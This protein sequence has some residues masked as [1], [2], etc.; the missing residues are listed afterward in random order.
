MTLAVMIVIFM[1]VAMA[2]DIS[3][4][5]AIKIKARHSLNLALRAASSQVDMESLT[6]AENPRLEIMPHEAQYKF[7]HILQTNLALDTN[8]Q[9]YSN[10]PVDGK[11]D[12]CFFL[13]VN[14]PP[15]T[16]SYN[17]YSEMID[18]VS[19]TGIIKVPIKMSSFAR[20]VI[21]IPEYQTMYVHST[22]GPEIL[23]SLK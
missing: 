6:D 3:H 5:Y 14:D 17:E 13:V 20:F 8:N 23:P 16:Y 10:S 18:R 12:V 7:N 9:P 15:Y 11:V 2:T 19:V 4:M 21:G 1:L 22:V